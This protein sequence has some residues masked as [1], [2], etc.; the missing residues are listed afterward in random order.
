MG[1]ALPGRR[2]VFQNLFGGVSKPDH[3]NIMHTPERVGLGAQAANPEQSIS[4]TGS[5][6]GWK[7]SM[8]IVQSPRLLLVDEPAAGLSD[9]ETAADG[10]ICC[11]SWQ[12]G[13]HTILVIEHDMEFVR[14]L[15]R[16]VT[17]LCEG[18]VLC[19]GPLS[20]VQADERVIEA[21][22]GR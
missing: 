7:I 2:R 19:E 15:N 20:K 4:A 5:G 17:V 11:W 12:A 14:Q 16:T 6:N 10:R 21:Y 8:V 18:K 9:E 3:D 1:L 13:T 22:L